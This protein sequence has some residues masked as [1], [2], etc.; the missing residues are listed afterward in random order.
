M[1]SKPCTDVGRYNVAPT[2]YTMLNL[3][4]SSLSKAK[5]SAADEAENRTIKL[6]VAARATQR[7]RVGA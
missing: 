7:S 2:P 1:C 4:L 3:T 5:E 6:L